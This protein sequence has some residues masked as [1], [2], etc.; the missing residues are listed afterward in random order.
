MPCSS[1]STTCF[2]SMATTQH[3]CTC[4]RPTSAL[5]PCTSTSD[6][7]SFA[8]ANLTQKGPMPSTR[9]RWASEPNDGSAPFRIE[10]VPH[11]ARL[12][13]RR[14]AKQT[15]QA[16]APGN[17]TSAARG[18]TRPHRAMPTRAGGPSAGRQGVGRRPRRRARVSRGS[19]WT[20]RRPHRAV[21]P[22]GSR[23]VR[24]L[25]G[26]GR[27]PEPSS[28][29]AHC[30]GCWRAG[31]QGHSLRSGVGAVMD[32]RVYP[33]RAPYRALGV[34]REASDRRVALAGARRGASPTQL[35]RPRSPS[36]RPPPAPPDARDDPRDA[37]PW[38]A[39]PEPE[40]Y[41]T[42]RPTPRP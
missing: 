28:S 8:P 3:S 1:D 24:C 12:V 40:R 39:G 23:R 19:G 13:T 32:T 14:V 16:G 36:T 27:R 25:G 15:L 31:D 10:E 35:E 2:S 7:A 30:V 42:W 41:A 11:N 5:D 6:G 34:G 33:S 29:L 18:N 21:C 38:G 17:G 22:G 4:S 20:L 37:S 9:R 26:G